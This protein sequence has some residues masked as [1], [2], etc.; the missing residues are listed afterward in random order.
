MEQKHIAYV[1][2]PF[3]QTADYIAVNATIVR[4][5]GEVMMRKGVQKVE[6][7]LDIATGVGT[8]AEL[9]FKHVV[10]QGEEPAVICLDASVEALEQ[11][12]ARLSP[13]VS[14]LELHHALVQ[15]M[16]L[17]EQSVDAAVW[18][19]GIHYLSPPMQEQAL[20]A[21]KRVLKPGGWFCFSTAFYAEARPPETHPFYMAQVKKAV[22]H[23]RSLGVT[24][25][26]R[27]ARA[28]SSYFLPRSHYEALLA[29]VDFT[30]EHVEEFA[31]RLYQ[32]AWEHISS[33]SQYAAGALHGYDP[34]LAAEAMRLAVAPALAEHGQRDE[35]GNLYVQRNWLSIMARLNPPALPGAHA[36]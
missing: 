28:E 15:E 29:K 30:M 34:A 35:H 6:R 26:E 17:P 31:G 13:V 5:W 23:L 21:I 4:R 16:T 7:L 8:I 27:E 18:G 25:R 2:E 36:G 20:H 10:R 19:N 22:M 9:F 12:N 24:R 33:F 14:K 11:A 3:A 1:Y 32:T